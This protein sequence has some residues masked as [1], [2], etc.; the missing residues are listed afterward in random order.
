MSHKNSMILIY[1]EIK[2]I[3][4]GGGENENNQKRL[5]IYYNMYR[6]AVW[7]SF[8]YPYFMKPE[9]MQ[10][11]SVFNFHLPRFVFHSPEK[12]STF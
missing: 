2:P 3:I 5:D 12:Y 10:I 1:K 4:F 7:A 8:L 9:R 6:E 11:S